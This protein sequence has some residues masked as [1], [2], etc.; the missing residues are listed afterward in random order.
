MHWE[1]LSDG[2]E[3]S[4]IIQFFDT[5]AWHKLAERSLQ[6]FIE[7][8]HEDGFIQNFGGYMLETGAT[9]WTMGEHFRYTKDTKWVKKIKP[10]ILKAVNYLSKWIEKNKR[11]ELTGNGYGMIDGKVADP[12]DPYH[13]F[14]LNGYAYLGLQRA[15]EMLEA[16]KDGASK[17]IKRMAEELKENTRKSFFSSMARSPVVPLG[18]RTWVPSCPPW[19][20]DDG[21]LVQYINGGKWYTHGTL[22]QGTVCWVHCI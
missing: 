6:Y 1:I 20:E 12:E 22:L 16:I 15:S 21:L 11:D 3:S 17:E 14:M 5:M 10:S 13:A 7:K 2:S 18:D 4:P 9:L 8:Q 19:P